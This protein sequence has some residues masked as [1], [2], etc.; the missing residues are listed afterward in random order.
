MSQIPDFFPKIRKNVA[1]TY[2]ETASDQAFLELE[3]P[4]DLLEVVKA[5]EPVYEQLLD[6]TI[7]DYLHYRKSS[8]PTTTASWQGYNRA[9][10]A[11]W[12]EQLANAFQAGRFSWA[13]VLRSY[14]FNHVL[15]IQAPI[16]ATLE[17][18]SVCGVWPA[19][20]WYEREAYDL[21]GVIFIGH[22]DL[23]RL[24]SDYSFVGHPLRKDYPMMGYEELRYD[25]TERR[26]L[27]ER[28]DQT[29]RMSIPKVIRL[30][31]DSDNRGAD[32]TV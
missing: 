5:L 25:G 6:L 23:R 32:V 19:A 1:F 3:S 28:H 12:E 18:A 16:P 24:L 14:R 22:P 8:W 30:S 7:I 13:A 2:K 26:C 31:D 17:I 11:H 4:K 20:N 21:F 15:Q 9:A 27:Y 29:Q 10:A